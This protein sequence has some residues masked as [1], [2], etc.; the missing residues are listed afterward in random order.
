MRFLSPIAAAVLTAAVALLAGCGAEAPRKTEAAA[1]APVPVAAVTVTPGAWTEGYEATGTVR[2]RIS[3]AISAR[4]MGYIREV[5]VQVGDRVRAGQPLITI[6]ARDL[7]ANYRR[8]EAGLAEARAAQSEVENAVAAAKAQLELAQT[9]FRRM[10]ELFDKKSISNQEYD[11]ANAKLKAAQAGYE[12]AVARRP[13]LQARIAQ[14]G[15][16]Q[17]A[18]SV[19]RSYAQLTAPF[20]GVVTAKSADP[21]TLATPGAPLLI[22]EREGTYRLE[23]PVEESRAGSI[24]NG[25]PVTVAIDS[26][27]RT[28]VA[29]VTEVVPAVDPGSRAY[30]VKIDLPAIPQ[31]RSGM[32]GRAIFPQGSR[33]VLAVPAAAVVERGQLRS[34]MVA[35]NGVARVRLITAGS[36]RADQVEVLSGLNAGEKVISPVPPNLAEGTRVEVRP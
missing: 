19:I 18:A 25:Q 27:D 15:Q 16:E 31:L 12:M 2:A 1:A 34:V 35:D 6:D 26:V 10:Q 4:V 28:V 13:Q 30:T 9:T 20:A 5:N 14:A 11:E 32:F 3:T 21:G 8:A 36:R 17:S 24:R 23:A 29:R 22:I 7:E 33:P